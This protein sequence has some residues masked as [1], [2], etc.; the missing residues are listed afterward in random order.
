[1][2]KKPAILLVLF[3]ALQH[4]AVQC[5]NCATSTTKADTEEPC[6]DLE[7]RCRVTARNGACQFNAHYMFTYCKKSCDFCPL[8]PKEAYIKNSVDD[9]R[10]WNFVP[11]CQKERDDQWKVRQCIKHKT[12]GTKKCACV[13]GN[14]YKNTFFTTALIGRNACN[15]KRCDD[16]LTLRNQIYEFAIANGEIIDAWHDPDCQ[17]GNPARWKKKQCIDGIVYACWIVDT[18]TGERLY[19]LTTEPPKR[20]RSPPP[21][22]RS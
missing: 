20:F 2:M 18:E 13:R 22:P 11:R 3:I 19:D 1:M 14:G 5:W 7:D 9:Y 17:A 4:N 15:P 12:R 21:L 8:K 6:V 10:Q 16:S